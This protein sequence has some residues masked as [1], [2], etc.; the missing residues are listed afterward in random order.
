MGQPFYSPFLPASIDEKIPLLEL[1]GEKYNEGQPPGTIYSSSTRNDLP[2][3]LQMKQDPE[4]GVL[5]IKRTSFECR[6]Q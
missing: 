3:D 1:T 4:S 2:H 5:S 6:P